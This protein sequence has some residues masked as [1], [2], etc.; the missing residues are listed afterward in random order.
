MKKKIYL[1]PRMIKVLNEEQLRLVK[2]ETW[3][4]GEWRC[5]T[6]GIYNISI[7]ES[8]TR[9]LSDVKFSWSEEHGDPIIYVTLD[10]EIN[11]ISYDNWE[12][13]LS[14]EQ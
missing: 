8:V 12:F 9:G 1:T 5:E 2:S 10:Q 4:N 14:V 6:V 11:K 3:K 13:S 7:E